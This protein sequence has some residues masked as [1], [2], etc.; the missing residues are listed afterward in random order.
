MCGLLEDISREMPPWTLRR[1]ALP[2]DYGFCWFETPLAIDGGAL[3]IVALAW[4]VNRRPAPSPEDPETLVLNIYG[5][6]VATS[7]IW[8][9][10]NLSWPW[11]DQVAAEDLDSDADTAQNRRMGRRIFRYAAAIFALLEQ[12]ILVTDRVG[13]DRAARRRLQRAGARQPP[14]ILVVRLRHHARGSDDTD[15]HPR[16]WTCR[17][18]VR[19]HWRQQYYPS[20]SEYRPIFI[21]PH[22]KGPDDK[23]LRAPAE[24]VFAVMR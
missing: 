15:G 13:V 1:E 10:F 12:R 9:L 8:P 23:P 21:L 6:N 20:T 5:G 7:R 11:G 16:A 19:G 4:G 2:T 24:R 17:W 14:A 3:R 18:I 22:I